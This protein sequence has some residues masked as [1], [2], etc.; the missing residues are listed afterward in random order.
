M[1]FQEAI[2]K[3][4]DLVLKCCNP[5]KSSFQVAEDDENEKYQGSIGNSRPRGPCKAACV[6]VLHRQFLRA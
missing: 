1:V 6:A 5:S 3:E 4:A 2:E